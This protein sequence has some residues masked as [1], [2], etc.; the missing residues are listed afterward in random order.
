ME[1]IFDVISRIVDAIIAVARILLAIV[2]IVICGI[3]FIGIPVW[4][5]LRFL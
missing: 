3:L 4:L 1:F 5:S 2:F